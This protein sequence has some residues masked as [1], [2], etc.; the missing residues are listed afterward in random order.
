MTSGSTT[1]TGPTGPKVLKLSTVKPG[2]HFNEGV[3]EFGSAQSP[4]RQAW[5]GDAETVSE[6]VQATV[7][8]GEIHQAAVT[9]NTGVA[10]VVSGRGMLATR[11]PFS[12]RIEAVR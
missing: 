11:Q 6:Q 3:R 7:D 4:L 5:S 1:S 9:T 10:L 12:D 2:N 8:L